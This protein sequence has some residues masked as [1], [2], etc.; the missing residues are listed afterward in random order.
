VV[1]F[2]IFNSTNPLVVNCNEK[3]GLQYWMPRFL[4]CFSK[5]V[6]T[7]SDKLQNPDSDW[8]W[9]RIQLQLHRGENVFVASTKLFVS[10]ALSNQSFC[11]DSVNFYIN[12]KNY[13]HKNF[14]CRRNKWNR[15]HSNSSSLRRFE[16]NISLRQQY[17]FLHDD[18]R[19]VKTGI[20]IYV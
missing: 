20:A 19:F 8:K 9:N 7:N 4:N 13:Y 5:I 2:T 18:T 3:V 16:Q 14:S 1:K 12:K 11:V 17:K 6:L 15:H 10:I